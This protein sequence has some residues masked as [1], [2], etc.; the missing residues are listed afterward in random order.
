MLH[1]RPVRI[2]IGLC[3]VLVVTFLGYK[4]VPVKATTVIASFM[5]Y[6]RYSDYRRKPK[7]LEDRGA[8][9]EQRTVLRLLATSRAA[10]VQV[11][12]I[13]LARR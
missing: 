5:S 12:G 9:M 4:E 1:L 8:I 13:A 6:G 3:G 10:R 7:L 2:L 11:F